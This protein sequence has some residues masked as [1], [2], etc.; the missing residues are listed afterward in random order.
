MKAQQ[1]KFFVDSSGCQMMKYRIHYSDND[2]L[3]IEGCGI[4]LWR[5]DKEGR[6]LWLHGEPTA[7]RA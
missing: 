7:V 4:K 1:F 2:W 3:P 5:Q 6:P